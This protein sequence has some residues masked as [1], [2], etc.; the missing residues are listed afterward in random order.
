MVFVLT[1][2]TITTE[3]QAYYNRYD[4]VFVNSIPMLKMLGERR[5][6]R[7]FK[8]L[9]SKVFIEGLLTPGNNT[10]PKPVRWLNNVSFNI[11]V[12]NADFDPINPTTRVEVLQCDFIF[13]EIYWPNPTLTAQPKYYADGTYN[14]W[15]FYPT[16]DLAY[17]YRA[18]FFQFPNFIDSTSQSNFFTQNAPEVLFFAI[19]LEAAIY[20]E[21][22]PRI[23]VWEK[24]Y[25]QARVALTEEDKQRIYD[26]YSVR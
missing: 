4:D 9:G 16:P 5:V 25:D 14:I 13:G 18:G 20:L 1:D 21:D 12:I 24:R 2:A 22:M 7:D 23:D 26:E 11:G 8:I 17:P 10:L 15:L 3:L 19:A 6:A